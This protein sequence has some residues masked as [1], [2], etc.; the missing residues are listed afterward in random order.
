MQRLVKLVLAGLVGLTTAAAGPSPRTLVVCAPGY[1][2]TTESAQPVMDDFSSALAAATGWSP[3]RTAA[4]YHEKLEDG[5][6]RLEQPDAAWLIS[7][8]PFFLDYEERLDLRPLLAVEP[9]AGAEE[10]WS[11]VARKGAIAGP[12]DLAGWRLASLAGYSPRFVERVAL[13]GWGPLPAEVEIVFAKRVLGELRKAAAGEP[14]AVLLDRAQADALDGLPFAAELAVVFTSAPH[15]ASLV[16][17][18]GDRADQA[19][20]ASLTEALESFG[21]TEA[22]REVLDAMRIQRFRKLEAGALSRV[23][24]ARAAG[25]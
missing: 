7:A 18:I 1:P 22:Q 8:L 19:T 17:A 21:G 3:E 20:S 14:V 5:L 4:T 15:V 12:E 25:G 10:R 9:V 13:D 16:C 24:R 23:E 11:L 2:G 6:A